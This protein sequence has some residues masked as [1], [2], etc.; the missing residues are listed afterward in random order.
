MK[1]FTLFLG[2]TGLVP[3][4]LLL[5]G[6]PDE[7]KPES[8]AD[9]TPPPVVSASATAAPATASATVT[10]TASAPPPAPDAGAPTD[11]GSDAKAPTRKK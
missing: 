5:A 3:L 10:A 2:L 1:R 9:A 11:A 4:T 7:N 6:C 8:A